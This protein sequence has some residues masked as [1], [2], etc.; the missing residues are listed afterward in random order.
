MARLLFGL[1]VAAVIFT[2]YA[3]A[4]CAFF[5][6]SRIRGLRRGWWIVIIL[7]VPIIGALLWFIIGRGRAERLPGGRART[8]AP[9]DDVDFLRRLNNDAAQDER[10]RRLEQE[11]AELDS[12]A[13]NDG[14]D[15]ADGT[16]GTERKR[17]DT[18]E[19]PGEPGP[20]G[21]PNG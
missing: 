21:R 15:D 18:P 2:I 6:R 14:A 10:I 8:V 19:T 12:D 13:S 17:P 9:D 16:L 5:D 1:G 4:D 11:L 3:A 7:F 20:S